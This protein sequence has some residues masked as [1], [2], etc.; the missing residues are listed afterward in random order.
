MHSHDAFADV[1]HYFANDAFGKIGVRYSN[2]KAKSNYAFTGSELKDDRTT[3]ATGLGTDIDQNAITADASYSQSFQWGKMRNEYVV[4]ADY[5]HFKTTNEQGRA[6]ALGSSL[7]YR[8]FNSLPY[9]DILG[10]ARSGSRGYAHSLSA[11]T[12]DEAGLYGKVVVRP[13]DSLS[14]IGGGRLGRYQ[15]KNGDTSDTQKKDETRFTGYAGVVWDF[16]PQNSLYAS[17][18]SLYRPQTAVGTDGKLLK[19]RKGDQIETGYKG[20]YLDDRLNTRVSLYRLQDKNAAASIPGDTTHYA[21][22]GKRVMQGVE[23]EASGALTDR[24]QI[25]AGYSY[26]DSKIKV[27]ATTRDDGIFLLMPRHSANLWTTYDI[28]N[29][30][31]IGGGVNT[32]SGIRSSQDVRG[33]GYS[34]VDAMA[35]WRITPKFQAQ[36]NVDNLFNRH[37]YT[38]VGSKNTFN[39]PGAERSIMANLRYDF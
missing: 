27:P 26:L 30:I 18:S 20:S 16:T 19:A 17:Y 10:S 13:L 36:L 24:W 32:M 22:L 28:T 7:D 3:T 34:T 25:H 9:S 21:A 33:G 6:R 23:L 8:N 2:R 35:S 39:I 38:R 11:E 12:L 5:N 29:D 1:S 31:T 4:G 37:Y 14:L 15:I